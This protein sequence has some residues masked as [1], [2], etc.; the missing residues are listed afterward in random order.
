MTNLRTITLLSLL[1]VPVAAVVPAY[2]ADDLQMVLAKL[3]SASLKFK[4]AAADITWSNVQTEPIPDKDVQAGTA[5]FER[6]NGQLSMAMHLKTDNGKSVPKEMLYAGGQFKLY[7]PLLKQ[8][9]VFQAGPNRAEYDTFLAL[10]IGGSGKDMQ[11]NWKVNYA[12][13]EK[14][15]GVSTARLEL[16]PL[17]DSVKKNFTKAILWIDLDNGI[18]VKQQFYDISG[19]YREVSYHNLKLNASVSPDAFTIKTPSGTKII[20]H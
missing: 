5:Q 8:E 4:S 10:G 1:F 13:A 3:D 2:G 16:A 19:N 14:V 11:K 18:A 20:N 6:K 9:T 15:D 17:Q 7:E 12:G